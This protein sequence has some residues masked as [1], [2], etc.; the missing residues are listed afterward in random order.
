MSFLIK[1]TNKK[2]QQT[3]RK[4]KGQISLTQTASTKA[5]EKE[6]TYLKKEN[7][8]QFSS[9]NSLPFFSFHALCFNTVAHHI[10]HL[11]A[12]LHSHFFSAVI[13]PSQQYIYIYIY[14]HTH[15]KK[16][17]SQYTKIKAI[18]IHTKKQGD[19]SLPPINTWNATWHFFSSFSCL[20]LRNLLQHCWAKKCDS[21]AGDPFWF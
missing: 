17:D 6:K 2:N 11:K 10:A 16:N 8:M 9:Y 15:T 1:K 5:E 3:K 7:I 12:M 4:C 20:K 14:T 21:H 18:H 19:N 13:L